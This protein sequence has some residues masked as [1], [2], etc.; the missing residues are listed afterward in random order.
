[1]TQSGNALK[2]VTKTRLVMNTFFALL[3]YVFTYN[4]V[5]QVLH[6]PGALQSLMQVAAEGVLALLAVYTLRRRVDWVVILSFLALAVYTN[7]LN[8]ESWMVFGN[9]LRTY[10][11]MLLMLPVVRFMFATR[12]RTTE[13][14][15]RMDT[16]LFIFL[17]IQF[18]C[19]VVQIFTAPYGN[20][21]YVGGSLGNL[22]S[23]LVSHLI[24][25]VS[26]YLMMRKWD[27]NISYIDNI[28]KNWLLP[29]LL[30]P[31]FLNE[32]KISFVF[33]LLYFILLIPLDRKFFKNMLYMLPIAAAAVV[34]GM[35]VYMST[36][37]AGSDVFTFEYLSEYV[38]SDVMVDLVEQDKLEEADDWISSSLTSNPD[39]PR[40]IKIMMVQVILDEHRNGGWLFGYGIGQY[41]GGT[42]VGQSKFAKRYSYLITGTMISGVVIIVELGLMGI[43]WLIFYLLVLFGVFRKWKIINHNL[44]VYLV[45]DFIIILLYGPDIFNIAVMAVFTYAAMMSVRWRLTE[46]IPQPDVSPHR[47]LRWLHLDRKHPKP[48]DDH[49]P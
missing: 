14:V 12:E 32:T 18:P 20:P 36:T 42:L 37:G 44:R 13:F 11:P 24:Y 29:V 3:W 16:N 1:M 35:E 49:E 22:A 33:M 15:R 34:G 47:V 5:I 23:G 21:D 39:Y 26:F 25:L 19:M 48:S 9:G 27:R 30:I 7:K 46:S 6:L 40:G 28:K 2:V 45:L 43:L 17:L 41:K 38:S 8:S 4:Y 31:T 10:L